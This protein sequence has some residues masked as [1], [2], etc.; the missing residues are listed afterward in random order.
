MGGWTG[1]FGIAGAE[2]GHRPVF[3]QI[4]N[5]TEQAGA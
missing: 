3:D 5:V 2:L 4:M 1:G